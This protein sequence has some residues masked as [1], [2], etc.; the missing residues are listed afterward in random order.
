ML[1]TG[2]FI[3]C[4]CPPGVAVDCRQLS[5][6]WWARIALKGVC[7]QACSWRMQTC[8]RTFAAPTQPTCI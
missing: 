4:S 6:S 7:R 2:A 5:A 3:S 1:T 8:G